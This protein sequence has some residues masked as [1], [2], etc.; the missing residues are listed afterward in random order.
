[1][2]RSPQKLV[3]AFLVMILTFDMREIVLRFCRCRYHAAADVLFLMRMAEAHVWSSNCEVQRSAEM[4]T[5][6]FA[7]P[8]QP[9]CG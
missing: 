6:G 1:M 9:T 3:A 7:Q 2:M 5:G 8:P 4:P